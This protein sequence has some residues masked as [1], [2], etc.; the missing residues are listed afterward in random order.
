[1][2]IEDKLTNQLFLKE[3]GLTLEISESKLFE[4]RNGLVYRKHQGQILFYVPAAL[5]TSVIFKYHNEMS[6]VGTGKTIQNI[7][8]SYWV[9]EMKLKVE[10]HIKSCLKCIAFTPNS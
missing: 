6:H 2:V 1:M 3:K 8:N 4:M 9:P 7:L 10:K 5:E